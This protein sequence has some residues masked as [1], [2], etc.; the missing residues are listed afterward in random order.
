MSEKLNARVNGAMDAAV[1]ESENAPSL[2]PSST[3]LHAASQEARQSGALPG[4]DLARYREAR[5]WTIL[6]V[7]DQLNLAAR[8]IAALEA[9]NYAALPAI[10]IVRGFIRAYAKLLK[11]DPVALLANM[12]AN[13]S[14]SL[15]EPVQHRTLAHAQFSDARMRD[16]GYGKNGSKWFSAVLLLVAA[17]GGVALAQHFD[18][19]PG[20]LQSIVSKMKT[21]LGLSGTDASGS[22]AESRSAPL[23]TDSTGIASSKDATSSEDEKKDKAVLVPATQIAPPAANAEAAM[24]P[25]V[26]AAPA[27]ADASL[28]LNVATALAKPTPTAT[29]TATLTADASNR[30]VLNLR[31]DSW[32]EIRGA[33][34]TVASKLYHAGSTEVF[35]ITEPVQL[36]VGNA[37]GVDATLRGSPLVLQTSAKNNVARLSL[38]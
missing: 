7:A 23:A 12:P 2:R 20:D 6:E 28:A 24:A 33:H 21:Q 26:P 37:A 10:A 8:Q 30:L 36:I 14:A 5:G 9:D 25:A 1:T 17:I 29:P 31:D 27:A 19:L 34:N 18:W 11:V 13:P 3:Q 22:I 35:N 16:S 15:S 4:A 38:K 32:I